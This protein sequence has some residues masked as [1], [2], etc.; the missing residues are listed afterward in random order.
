VQ[1]DRDPAPAWRDVGAELPR[2]VLAGRLDLVEPGAD[3]LEV[4]SA[5]L[6]ELGLVLL[7]THRDASGARRD[8]AA[9]LLRVG[10]A[11]LGDLLRLVHAGPAR[12]RDLVGLSLETAGDAAP[13]GP[14]SGAELG[15]VLGAGLAEPL[16]GRSGLRGQRRRGERGRDDEEPR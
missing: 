9:E 11:G 13:A 12:R 6:A 10:E 16:T 1:T 4:R 7:D 8:V 3:L 14:H 2:V 5:G 15:D